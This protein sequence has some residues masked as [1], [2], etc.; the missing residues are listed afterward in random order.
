MSE[1]GIGADTVN[2]GRRETTYGTEWYDDDERS[3]SQGGAAGNPY[4][5]VSKTGLE[6]QDKGVSKQISYVTQFFR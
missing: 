3:V 5:L 2:V 6:S 1:T 4:R